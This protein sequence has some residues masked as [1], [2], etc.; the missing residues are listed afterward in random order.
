[1]LPILLEAYQSMV[2]ESL[3]HTQEQRVTYLSHGLRREDWG[4]KGG[5]DNAQPVIHLKNRRSH[6]YMAAYKSWRLWILNRR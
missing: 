6:E 1:M 2:C 4:E 3:L 5:G